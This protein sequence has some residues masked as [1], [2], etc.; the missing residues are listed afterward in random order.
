MNGNV[1][2][3]TLSQS[4]NAPILSIESELN[5]QTIGNIRELAVLLNAMRDAM[6]PEIVGEMVGSFV[7]IVTLADQ[8][9][10]PST[11]RLVDFYL[12]HAET[13][14]QLFKR[15]AKMEDN[16]FLERLENLLPVMGAMLDVLSPEIL[17]S[18]LR[19]VVQI[20]E[21]LDAFLQTDISKKFPDIINDFDKRLQETRKQKGMVQLM[22]QLREPELQAGLHTVFQLLRSI[23]IHTANNN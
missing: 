16:G 22:K 21:L 3:E 19:S 7:K 1:N 5:E 17:I 20:I 11:L 6:T 14:E 15:I 12:T 13:V 9:N 4:D 10:Q 18:L 2:P 8:L 23:G